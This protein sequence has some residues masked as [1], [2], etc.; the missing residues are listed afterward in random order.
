MK[1]KRTLQTSG[2][3]THTLTQG[4]K[5]QV[6]IE[7]ILLLVVSVLIATILVGFVDE[8]NDGILFQKWRNLLTTIAQDMSS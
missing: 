4:R 7:Y 8:T 1:Q 6:V 3:L 5:G 2:K